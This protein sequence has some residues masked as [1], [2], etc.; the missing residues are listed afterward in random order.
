GVFRIVGQRWRISYSM[1]FQGTCTWIL[2][3][4]GPTAHV[5]N[6]ATGQAVSAF[7]LNDGS[8]QTETFSTGPGT[9]EIRVTPGGDTAKWS[10]HV[11]DWF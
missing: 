3:C 11:E 10:V 4:D 6:T 5:I 2:F 9:Y 1:G 7:G 8:G